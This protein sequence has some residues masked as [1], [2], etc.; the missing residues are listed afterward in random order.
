[1]MEWEKRQLKAASRL[2]SKLADKA[3]TS[4]QGII[5]SILSWTLNRAKEV[6]GWLS[7]NLFALITDVG[8]L[9]YTYFMTKTRTK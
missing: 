4:L 7:Q 3:L 5:G 9:I 6:V 1:M 8:V 2:L